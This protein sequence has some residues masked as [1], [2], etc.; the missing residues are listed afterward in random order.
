MQ[1]Q[2]NNEKME[3]WKNLLENDEYL[4]TFVTLAHSF[5]MTDKARLKMEKEIADDAKGEEKLS[6]KVA[7]GKKTVKIMTDDSDIPYL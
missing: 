7:K 4:C 5:L 2:E 6:R 1:I 3:N